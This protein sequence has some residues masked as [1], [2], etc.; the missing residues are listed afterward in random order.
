MASSI[1]QHRFKHSW[2]KEIQIFVWPAASPVLLYRGE[3]HKRAELGGCQGLHCSKTQQELLQ[4]IL[5]LSQWGLDDTAWLGNENN[6]K[7]LSC[8]EVFLIFPKFQWMV[9][10][11]KIKFL[12]EGITPSAAG[13]QERL[14]CATP[15]EKAQQGCPRINTPGIFVNGIENVFRKKK[16]LNH[17]LLWPSKN[18][19][20]LGINYSLSSISLPFPVFLLGRILLSCWTWIDNFKVIIFNQLDTF[21]EVLQFKKKPTLSLLKNEIIQDHF[22]D[23]SKNIHPALSSETHFY[24][25]LYRK[26]Q[27]LCQYSFTI[28]NST[29]ESPKLVVFCPIPTLQSSSVETWESRVT[30]SDLVESGSDLWI[31]SSGFAASKTE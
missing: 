6:C 17:I 14:I 3:E 13:A 2:G 5:L 9:L 29:W 11:R 15:L 31:R 20:W 8:L 27:S 22:Q 24:S 28:T 1:L 23:T 18:S 10:L 25:S 19:P 30:W 26:L 21:P 7:Q 4:W 12:A 16:R